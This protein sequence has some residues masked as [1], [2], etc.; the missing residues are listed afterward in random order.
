MRGTAGRR[1]PGV[2]R[3]LARTAQC[4]DIEELR[5][6]RQEPA[7]GWQ[8]GRPARAPRRPRR[9]RAGKGAAS[10]EVGAADRAQF[11]DSLISLRRDVDL[12]VHRA[13]ARP[14]LD[15]EDGR[16]PGADISDEPPSLV[17]GNVEEWVTGYLAPH[18]RRRL[19]GA[20]TWCP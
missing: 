1:G 17:Y 7:R 6:H 14:Q 8:R 18:I 15:T 12:V 19:G 9:H 3:H 2:Q 4:P 5:P 16:I 13:V 20:F 11:A 10:R